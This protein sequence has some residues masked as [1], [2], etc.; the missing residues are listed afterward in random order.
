[1]L[2]CFRI[3]DIDGKPLNS[4]L[5]RVRTHKCVL[6]HS[7]SFVSPAAFQTLQE[8]RFGTLDTESPP[9][10]WS[11]GSRISH[12]T[13]CSPTQ[14]FPKNNG[15]GSFKTF[16]IACANGARSVMFLGNFFKGR[17][18]CPTDRA[19]LRRFAFGDVAA[20]RADVVIRRALC[21]QVAQCSFIEVCMLGL[22]VSGLREN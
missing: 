9:L 13:P 4:R 7:F 19:C 12:K 21:Y 6:S 3:L 8:L 15:K 22:N 20:D 14:L 18:G 11:C 16:L 10:F 2:C 1:M 5:L 17:F